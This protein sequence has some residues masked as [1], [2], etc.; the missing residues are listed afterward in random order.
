MWRLFAQIPDL[1]NGDDSRFE[2]I[3]VSAGLAEQYHWVT[4]GV[5]GN[6]GD[7]GDADAYLA[8]VVAEAALHAHLLAAKGMAQAKAD[9]VA[10][11]L[12]F[13]R[14]VIRR[15]WGICDRDVVASQMMSPEMLD[16]AAGARPEPLVLT[17]DGDLPTG[18]SLVGPLVGLDFAAARNRLEA[19]VGTAANPL[20]EDFFAAVSRCAIGM[21]ACN[22]V[23][24][25][26]TRVHHYVDPH[27]RIC[28]AVVDQHWSDAVVIPGG[29]TMDEVKDAVCHKTCHVIESSKLVMLAR[30]AEVRARLAAIGE[31]AAAVR[32]PAKFDPERAASA[33]AAVVAKAAGAA[34]SANVAMDRSLVEAFVADVEAETRTSAT[35]QGLA[36]AEAK[37][38]AFRLAHG[39]DIA[40]CAG[41]LSA[42]YD[43][44]NASRRARSVV[45]AFSI[46]SLMEEEPSA[47]ADGR[48]Q[49]E[50]YRRWARERAR[51]GLLPGI[52]VF[53]AAAPQDR[54]EETQAPRSGP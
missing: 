28:D 10:L 18:K 5:M 47:V 6:M 48:N 50:L 51:A 29:L 54:G 36:A 27:K 7:T 21:P 40:W 31:G 15:A 11:C 17:A 32:I 49:Y 8:R 38:S 33:Y 16:T 2:F 43:A 37:V 19:M 42:L 26:A 22:G 39:Y 46:K 30:S 20:H 23:T 45:S 12:A 52:G 9:A 24:M 4:D 35:Q 3:F 1:V 44:S 13:G 34:A 41:F 53:G 14:S 25:V